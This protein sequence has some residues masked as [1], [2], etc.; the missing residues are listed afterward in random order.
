M[1]ENGGHALR[2]GIVI[3]IGV[4][5]LAVAIFSIGGGLR[6]LGGSEE[7]IARFRRVNGLQVGAPVYLSGVNIGSVSSIQFPQDPRANYVVVRLRVETNA[8]ERV[9]ADS[10]AKIESLGLLGDKFLLLTAGSESAPSAQPDSLLK[11]QDPVNYAALLQA[12]GTGDLVANVLAISNGMRQLLESINQGNGILAELIRGSSNPNEKAL[13]LES[14]RQ[15]MNNVQRLT[16]RLDL[17]V[18]RI[19]HGQGI[20]GALLSPRTDGQRVVANIADASESLRA[21]S[22]RLEQTSL[23][24]HDLAARLDTANGLLPRLM[25]DTRYAGEV[26]SNVRRSSE[27]L[28]DALDKID[29]RQGTLGLLINDPTLYNRTNNLVSANGW[30]FSLLRGAYSVTHPFGTTASPSYAPPSNGALNY[31]PENASAPPPSAPS[32]P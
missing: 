25:L 30:A 13:T 8:A 4:A 23:E 2:V 5:I 20:A 16:Q 14:I 21:A 7:L 28:R 24:F 10:V 32:T 26:M 1:A 19:E 6:W 15:T 18:D 17:A 12:R 9:R 3:V 29:S 31:T 27:D 11:A 22:Q